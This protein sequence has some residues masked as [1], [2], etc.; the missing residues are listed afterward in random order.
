MRKKFPKIEFDENAPERYWYLYWLGKIVYS[1]NIFKIKLFFI[2]TK[3]RNNFYRGFANCRDFKETKIL[4]IEVLAY[5]TPGVLYDTIENEYIF[6][7]SYYN[8]RSNLNINFPFDYRKTQ[9]DFSFLNSI[10]SPLDDSIDFKGLNYYAFGRTNN[11]TIL[12]NYVLSKYLF[13]RSS[14]FISSLFRN[15]IAEL[16]DL[17]DI[18]IIISEGKRVGLLKYNNNLL[19][20]ADV[21]GIAHLFFI[22]DNLGTSFFN[23]IESNILSFFINNRDK[24]EILKEGVYLDANFPF[25][26]NVN[27]TIQGKKFK[28]NEDEFFISERIVKHEASSTLF[29]I[30]EI[31]I[32]EI[33]PKNSTEERTAL[34]S[35]DINAIRQPNI[36]DVKLTN[37]DSLGNSQ[38]D[39][40]DNNFE[41]DNQNGFQFPIKKIIRDTQDSAYNV[42][43]IPTDDE[44]NT[45]TI[46]N[47][48]SDSTSQEVRINF[49][50]QFI[51]PMSLSKFELMRL[52]VNKLKELSVIC[53]FDCLNH[54]ILSN[55]TYM[56]KSSSVMVISLCYKGNYFYVIELENDFA[57]FVRSDTLERI[58]PVK[59]DFFIK[60]CLDIN[61]E[62]RVWTKIREQ[63]MEILEKYGIII[64]MPLK[65]KIKGLKTTSDI[66]KHMADKI[67]NDRIIKIV[68]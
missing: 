47:Q 32:E 3:E 8:E 36:G 27:F 45:A 63:Q 48:G 43:L 21:R 28:E 65:H 6:P 26:E 68:A 67:Y 54:K 14:K 34:D 30:D 57:G 58:D 51:E 24:P 55:N 49:V 56:I 33:Y 9:K 31:R 66:A 35:I 39:I 13:L 41:M 44:L 38:A 18:K 61:K 37:T 2:N 46:I 50:E 12:T 64:E 40:V 10:Y 16:F 1:R 5:L 42:K 59:L 29:L 53:E 60:V 4:P 52:A 20:E 25:N 15:G 23:Y 22:K 7:S 19:G 17:N 11:R 62:H